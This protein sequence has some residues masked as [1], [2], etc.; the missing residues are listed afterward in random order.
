MEFVEFV[1]RA[2]WTQAASHA[3]TT[4]MTRSH[5]FLAEVAACLVTAESVRAGTGT[6]PHAA[7]GRTLYLRLGRRQRLNLGVITADRDRR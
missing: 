3:A 1:A 4:A 6:P 7:A 5:R 2:V